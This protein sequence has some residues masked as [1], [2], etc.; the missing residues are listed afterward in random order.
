MD[1]ETRTL[2][3]VLLDRQRLR[4]RM[5]ESDRQLTAVLRSWSDT[6]PFAPR[7]GIATEAGATIALQHMGLLPEPKSRELTE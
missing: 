6:R 1:A 4:E 7:G 2:R 3:R 5:V